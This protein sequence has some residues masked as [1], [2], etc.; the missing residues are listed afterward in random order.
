MEF[1]EYVL[2]SYAVV[3]GEGREAKLRSDTK[4]ALDLIFGLQR[5]TASLTEQEKRQV[6]VF[7]STDG[8]RIGYYKLF[9]LVPSGERERVSRALGEVWNPDLVQSKDLHVLLEHIPLAELAE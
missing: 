5:S 6:K 4:R 9:V 3:A 8:E 7:C 1:T 2:L